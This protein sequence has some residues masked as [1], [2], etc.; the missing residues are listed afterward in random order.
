METAELPESVARARGSCTGQIY[1]IKRIYGGLSRGSLE[2]AALLLVFSK[3]AWE[4]R[5][6]SKAISAKSLFIPF[7]YLCGAVGNEF[8][9][10]QQLNP[11]NL[12]FITAAQLN[13]PSNM[14]WKA[15]HIQNA[16]TVHTSINVPVYLY[17][18]EK[19]VLCSTPSNNTRPYN[20]KNEK[21]ATVNEIICIRRHVHGQ[22]KTPMEIQLD[23]NLQ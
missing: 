12:S 13:N 5:L 2:S 7:F 20:Y 17:Y 23:V 11:R 22:H 15:K 14:H 10:S 18:R 4:P 19:H 1:I 3:C 16:K 6:G 21:I 8:Q 9:S